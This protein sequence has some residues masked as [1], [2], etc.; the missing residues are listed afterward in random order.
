MNANRL[1]QQALAD[2]V[3][4]AQSALSA[5]LKDRRVPTAAHAKRL[6]DHFGV[7]LTVFLP[8]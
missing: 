2:A 7:S 5:F 8:L 4:I 6:G 3:G 1:T